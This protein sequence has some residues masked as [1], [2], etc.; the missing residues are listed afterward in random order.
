MFTEITLWLSTSKDPPPR[1]DNDNYSSG[2]PH[3][4]PISSSSIKNQALIKHRFGS[5]Q[6]SVP[7]PEGSAR[8]HGL[9]TD[10]IASRSANMNTRASSRA[11]LARAGMKI[12][13]NYLPL[14]STSWSGF[15][16]RAIPL[17]LFPAR[18]KG[19]PG[20]GSPLSPSGCW[21]PAW[22]PIYLLARERKGLLMLTMLQS[23]SA[24]RSMGKA[25]DQLSFLARGKSISLK[26]A[27]SHASADHNHCPHT[28][29]RTHTTVKEILMHK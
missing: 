24:F 19:Y 29:T 1:S 23:I 11:S 14:A 28:H 3:P 7:V 5:D 16:F 15:F 27:A 6:F 13:A 18:P 2:T 22:L 26:A 21:H 8:P 10:F 17:L 25:R 12:A 20:G 9:E 4:S